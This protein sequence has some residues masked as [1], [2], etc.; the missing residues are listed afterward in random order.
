MINKSGVEKAVYDLLIAIGDDPTRPGLTETPRRVAMMYEEILGGSSLK[1]SEVIKF[2]NEDVGGEIITVKDIPFYSVCEHHLLPFF[3]V[4][5]ICYIPAPQKLLGLSKIVRIV[6]MYA[7][8][9][10]LQER[11][12]RQIADCLET[13]AGAVGVMV[14]IQ[15]EHMCIS[16]RGIKKPGSKTVTTALRGKL[17]SVPEFRK[18]AFGLIGSI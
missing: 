16:M 13:E 6:E 7:R 1:P 2:F 10:Q 8:R 18:E 15:A 3:G 4:V 17:E 11:L 5:H 14:L 12:T 9:L